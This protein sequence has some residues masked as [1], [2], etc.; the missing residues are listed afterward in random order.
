MYGCKHMASCTDD[1]STVAEAVHITPNTLMNEAVGV[2]N[3]QGKMADGKS[4]DDGFVIIVYV[5]Y[6]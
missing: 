5:C 1:Q 2:S 6:P 4:G 3:G